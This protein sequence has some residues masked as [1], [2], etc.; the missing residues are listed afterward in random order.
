M[1]DDN[2]RRPAGTF[3]LTGH[4]QRLLQGVRSF[5]R[6][7]PLV[8]NG[9]LT[10]F[11]ILFAVLDV[12]S[13]GWRTVAVDPDVPERLVLTMSVAFS[14]PLLWSRSHPLAVLVFMAP[15]SLANG[16]TGRRSRPRSCRR[17]SSSTSRSGDR[18]AP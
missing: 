2:T 5:D 1:T 9:L 15:F 4:I 17:S 3:P 8:W 13:D 18:C 6:R 11:W 10:T 14:A 7:R 16:W 12:S